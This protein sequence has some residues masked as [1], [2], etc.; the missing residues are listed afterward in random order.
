MPENK[1]SF[2]GSE[3]GH[4]IAKD[5]SETDSLNSEKKDSV[6]RRKLD[7]DF[8]SDSI[9]KN[10]KPKDLDDV[11]YYFE[12]GLRKIKPYYYEYQAFAKGRWLGRSVFDIFCTEFRDRS[13]DYYAYA[14]ETGLITING[15]VVTKE[16]IVKNQ[17]IIG[18]KIHRHEP[19]ITAD[20]IKLISMEND[21]IVIDK[22]GSVPVHPSG[23]YRHNTVLHILQKEFGFS[24]LYT[25]NRLDRLTSG[26]M[27]LSTNKE[28]AQEFE[29]LMQERKIRKE[30][31]C[32]VIGEFPTDDVR[33]DKPIMTV[34]HKLGLNVVHPKGKP[35]TTIFRRE[36]YN[37]RTSVVRCEP[38]TGR[39]H[40]IRVHLQYLGYVIA[41]DPLY[42]H[43]VWGQ[44]KGKGGIDEASTKSVINN[45]INEGLNQEECLIL[46]LPTKQSSDITTSNVINEESLESLEEQSQ[47]FKSLGKC[48][49]CTIPNFPDPEPDQLF[50]WLHALKYEVCGCKYETGLPYWAKD[51]FDGDINIK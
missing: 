49:E 48:E 40:Q 18:H 28:K 39:T 38:I 21:L 1:L 29:Q 33:C 34:S 46:N 36:S 11:I 26:I 4:N 3:I 19:P 37:G 27:F 12:N 47:S 24:N 2:L 41:N 5:E 7:K 30:Y 10:N 35:C 20:S 13:R 45:L 51:D 17:D 44:Q 32:R 6:K 15:K 22:P 43:N 31:L 16:K 25:L 23:R 9:L 8:H 42:N 50:I 14:I